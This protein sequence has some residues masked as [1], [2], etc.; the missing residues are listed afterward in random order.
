MKFCNLAFLFSKIKMWRWKNNHYHIKNISSLTVI[1]LF[2]KLV[3]PPC[4]AVGKNEYQIYS[5][6]D[7]CDLIVKLN[8]SDK[9][10][11]NTLLF[12]CSKQND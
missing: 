7:K 12:D 8:E 6:V 4:L 10:I 3:H 2:L 11:D 5:V 1:S 9:D